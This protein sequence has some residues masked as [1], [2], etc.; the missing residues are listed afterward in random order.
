MDFMTAE[1]A[2]AQAEGAWTS[3]SDLEGG[4][5]PLHEV[6]DYVDDGCVVYLWE[7]IP[8]PSSDALA[9]DIESA[10]DEWVADDTIWIA[11][12]SF[13]QGDIDGCRLTDSKTFQ[14]GL[15]AL[16]DSELAAMGKSLA[17]NE[18]GSAVVTP[19][20]RAALGRAGGE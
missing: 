17:Y 7:P 19:E 4:A 5:A 1:Q 12:A 18:A 2:A 11:L 10:I 9:R 8:M 6:L 20:L 16:L 3:C 14:A 13:C 15:R